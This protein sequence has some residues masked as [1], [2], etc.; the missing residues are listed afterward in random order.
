MAAILVLQFADLDQAAYDAVNAKLG[1][2][3]ATGSGD[4][5]PGLIS[6]AGGVVDGGGLVVVEVWDSRASQAAFMES[7][8]GPAL[9]ETGAGAPSTVTW[10]DAIGYQAP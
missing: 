2:D 5:P 7:R 9:A 10:A 3:M 6:H 4:W 8:L 1:I